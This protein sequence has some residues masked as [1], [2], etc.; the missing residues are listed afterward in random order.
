MDADINADTK[1]TELKSSMI[2]F[3]QGFLL[4]EKL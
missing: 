1:K 4:Y 3:N 2:F